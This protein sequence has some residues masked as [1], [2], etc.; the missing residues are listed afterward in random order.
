M[1]SRSLFIASVVQLALAFDHRE[2]A[3]M[4]PVIFAASVASVTPAVQSMETC[5]VAVVGA[6]IGGLAL[7]RAL[8]RPA[9]PRGKRAHQQSLRRAT[10]KIWGVTE[11]RSSLFAWRF[12]STGRPLQARASS[13]RRQGP[14]HVSPRSAIGISAAPHPRRI[15]SVVDRDSRGLRWISVRLLSQVV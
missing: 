11:L 12:R 14:G 4:L 10:A 2:Q 3:Q 8:P 6:G 7:A 5:D 1:R 15:I 13:S 9:E